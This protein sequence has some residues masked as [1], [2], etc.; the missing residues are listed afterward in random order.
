MEKR[1]IHDAHALLRGS[2]LDCKFD[3]L[4]DCT[5]VHDP[6]PCLISIYI[7][8]LLFLIAN[9][10]LYFFLHNPMLDVG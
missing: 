3:I 10:F 2:C 9:L 4:A 7:F 5:S 6:H 1:F 8:I